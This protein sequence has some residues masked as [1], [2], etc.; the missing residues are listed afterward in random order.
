VRLVELVVGATI[1]LVHLALRARY[2]RAPLAL[3]R[4]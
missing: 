3:A 2:D 1:V 4:S